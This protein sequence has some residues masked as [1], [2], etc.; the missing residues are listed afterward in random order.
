MSDKKLQAK[1]LYFQSDLNKT[2]IANLLHISRRTLHYWIVEG[3]WQRL[4]S[5]A[6]HMPSIIAENCYHILHHM[7]E[8]YLSERRLSKPVT[9]KEIDA[10]HKLTLTIG[11]LKG[12]S[13]LNENMEMFG[14]F[15]NKLQAEAPALA[16]QLSPFVDKYL[17][18]RASV[19]ATD[20]QPPHLNE[21]GRI[22]MTHG[23]KDID[24]MQRDNHDLF[25]W[26]AARYN[27]GLEE[28]NSLLPP[29]EIPEEQIFINPYADILNDL[30]IGQD[31][32]E[33]EQQEN[34][35]ATTEQKV[36]NPKCQLQLQVAD[37]QPKAA[38]LPQKK[39]FGHK[40]RKA[41]G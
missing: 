33:T 30:E 11:K 24:E 41:L 27:A 36:R 12:R 14:Y 40:L 10:M 31:I 5:S 29:L 1:N 4:K 39:I 20:V 35:C 23:E 2:Q 28:T 38:P 8:L 19:Y 18:E 17:S 7:T 37:N 15:I 9:P 16:D 22:P 13:V 34:M 26:N 25:A 6:E 32:F 3:S 21:I